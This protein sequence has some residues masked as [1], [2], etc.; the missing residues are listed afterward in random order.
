[1]TAHLNRKQQEISF[2]FL[3][4]LKM[5]P[6]KILD[7]Y[8]KYKF[9]LL[10][11]LLFLFL[12]SLCILS[13]YSIISDQK[14]DKLKQLEVAGNMTHL[15]FKNIIR[16]NT[17]ALED[18]RDRIVESSGEFKTYLNSET[19]RIIEQNPAIEFVEFIDSTGVITFIAPL[20][21]NKQAL[22]LDLKKIAYRYPSWLENAKDTLTNIT[23]WVNLTQKGQAFLV[24]VP[25]Y[26]DNRF[27][28]TITAGMDFK[29]QFDNISS[30]Q[31]IFS[32]QIKDNAGNIF[33][34]Y[35]NPKLKS[36]KE[37]QI[38]T[39]LL[40]PI[41]QQPGVTWKFEFIFSSKSELRATASQNYLLALGVFL[42]MLTGLLAYFYM[43]AKRR[44]QQYMIM[45]QKLNGLNE[46]LEIERIKAED[47]ST[48]KTQF[49]SHMS[50]EIRTPLSAILSISEILEGKKLSGS[51][52]EFLKLMQNSSQTL[53]NLVNNILNIDRI[54]SGKIE[55]AEQVFS[56]FIAL[57]KI[58][59]I[60]SQAAQVKGLKII[61][62]FAEVQD[63]R[64]VVGDISRTEQIFTNIVSNAVKFTEVGTI[65]VIYGEKEVN[66]ELQI[67]VSVADT[68]LGID[69]SQLEIIF[70]RFKQLDF[71][72]T[73]KHQGSGLGLAITKM[74]VQLMNGTIG[75]ESELGKG[76]TFK[77]SLRYPTVGI[78]DNI[79]NERKY[80]D[81][82]HLNVLIV[83]DNL[84]NRKILGKILSKKNI[85]PDFS[86][87]G[88]DAILKCASKSYD[89]IFM[90]VHMPGKD[91][92]EIV[93]YL[94]KIGNTAII[95]GFS[96][97][98]TKESV[99]R[100]I[101]VGMNDYLTK[102]I[103]QETLFAIF[104]KYFL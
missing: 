47:A 11:I 36:F 86:E 28:G 59:E 39:Q 97:D 15:D 76:A 20:E 102:P 68:G 52:K 92:F 99:E 94:R 67:Y 14:I 65:T 26:Y 5:L 60:Y 10:S 74:L 31:N 56:P 71:G 32:V 51:E 84:L 46:E 87:D 85:T 95:L 91:G 25:V 55:L 2:F 41:P 62:N 50:H 101:K 100:G 48:A 3:V 44:S 22:N 38:F 33:Y 88:A 96:A 81:Y 93:Q 37:D 45:N 24:D 21:P 82:S 61:T 8:T 6:T 30:K 7:S 98:A 1:M 77:V 75:V 70:E 78:Q 80:R 29:N 4:T 90:D 69:P 19:E 66:G 18:L 57:Q 104:S 12:S 83:D 72:I 58:V 103:Q 9:G 40:K 27:H 54:E 17:A 79:E 42:S 35:N 63:P 13:Y 34:S 43:L 16:H 49:L 89:L 23:P 73:K 53:L 64:V